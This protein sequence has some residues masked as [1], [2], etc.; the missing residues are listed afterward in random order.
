MNATTRCS[1]AVLMTPSESCESRCD[2]C[3]NATRTVGLQ[4]WFHDRMQNQS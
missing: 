2:E 3:V 4:V 1:T